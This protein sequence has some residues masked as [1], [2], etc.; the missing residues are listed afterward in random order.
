[1]RTEAKGN[2]DCSVVPQWSPVRL[3]NSIHNIW[4][5]TACCRVWAHQQRAQTQGRLCL[6]GPFLGPTIQT[7]KFQRP[8]VGKKDHGASLLPEPKSVGGPPAPPPP[9]PP[10]PHRGLSPHVG[11]PEPKSHRQALW[12]DVGGIDR[13]SGHVGGAPKRNILGRVRNRTLFSKA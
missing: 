8:L 7:E 10:T 12:P 1:V 5:L 6:T 11:R 3:R 2:D 13:G 9:P 4:G